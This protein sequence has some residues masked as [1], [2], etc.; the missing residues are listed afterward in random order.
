MDTQTARQYLETNFERT[1]RLAVV[2]LHRGPH[3]VKQRIATTERIIQDDFQ[4]RLRFLN[5]EY[6]EIYD[7]ILEEMT[8]I[9]GA[10][11]DPG[12]DIVR[13]QEKLNGKAGKS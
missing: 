12:Q 7:L 6:Y 3:D 4:R 10:R 1:D 5:K 2:A 13:H 8:L 11:L 9:E